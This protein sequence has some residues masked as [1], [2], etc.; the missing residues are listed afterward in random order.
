LSTQTQN[1]GLVKQSGNENYDV[2]VVNQ[3]LDKIDAAVIAKFLE[4][5][6]YT[7]TKI[8]ELINAA[9]GALDTLD[10]LA[11]A[12]GDDPNFR[13]T[14]LNAIAAKLSQSDFNAFKTAN[15]ASLAD[16]VKL[17]NNISIT[18]TGWTQNSNNQLWEYK[19]TDGDIT[20][21]TMVDVNIQL[22]YLE[23]A[24][25][26]K[27][28]TQSFAGYVLLYATDK[29]IENLVVDMKLLRQVG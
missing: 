12:L 29:P 10:E 27:S 17:K 2:D 11:N 9:P 20:V 28:V 13:T 4:A 3:N 18:S 6:G 5:K 21:N 15:D 25:S 26:L 14:I 8:L 7:D 24:E 19:I 22:N 23:N 16:I 1:L